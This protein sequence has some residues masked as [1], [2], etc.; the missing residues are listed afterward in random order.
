MQ[1][2]EP[3]GRYTAEQAIA[4]PFFEEYHDPEDEPVATHPFDNE[5]EAWVRRQMTTI[6]LDHFSPI[7]QVELS[8]MPPTHA[9]CTRV[10]YQVT[11]AIGC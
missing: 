3:G 5:C 6:G 11:V 8:P 7:S 4:H 9:P 1:V 2:Y 10:R